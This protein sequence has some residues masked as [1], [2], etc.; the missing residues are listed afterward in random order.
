MIR[1]RELVDTIEFLRDSSFL[2]SAEYDQMTGGM[3]IGTFREAAGR[4][5][6]HNRQI[7]NERQVCVLYFNI[8]DFKSYNER[9]GFEHG[10]GLIMSWGDFIADAFP[11]RMVAHISGDQFAALVYTDEAIDGIKKVNENFRQAVLDL[12]HNAKVGIFRIDSENTDVATACDKAKI[13]ADSIKKQ[14]G[15]YYRYYDEA[16][17]HETI[18]RRYIVANIERAVEEGY[19]K[20]FYQPVIRTLTTKVCGL[21]A[22]C[23]WDD[24]EYG[25]LRPDIIIS[26]LE[27]YH[28]IDIL[29]TYMIRKM[30]EDYAE[31]AK[32]GHKLA[33]ISF[34]VSRLDFELCD[35][36][37]VLRDA[38]EENHVPRNMIHIEIT[39]SVLTKNPEYIRA[40]ITKFHDEGY[41]VWMDDFGSG[42]SS[43]N[44][45]KDFDFDV[46]KID[47][48]F[49]RQF[50]ARSR[51]IIAAIVGMAKQ[52]GIRTLAEGVETQEQLEFLRDIGCE[53]AQGYL[54]GKPQSYQDMIEHLQE[55]GYDF[56]PVSMKDYYDE[57]GTINLMST[58]PLEYDRDVVL[59]PD[60]AVSTQA[61][62]VALYEYVNGKGHYLQVN[63]AYKAE[64]ATAGIHSVEEAEQSML[65]EDSILN[66][67][68]LSYAKEI[69]GTDEIASI[70]FVLNGNYCII[71]ARSVSR[72]GDASAYLVTLQNLSEN[73]GFNQ[74]AKLSSV[75]PMLYLSFEVVAIFYPEENRSDVVYKNSG[76]LE[77]KKVTDAPM[78]EALQYY[79][80]N[81]IHKDDV[82]R[83]HEF[84]DLDTMEQRVQ[85]AGEHI[86]TDYFRFLGLD[87]EYHWKQLTLSSTGED[88]S[89]RVLFSVR[90]TGQSKIEEYTD[91]VLGTISPVIVKE[92]KYLSG[93]NRA[94]AVK[95]FKVTKNPG[96]PES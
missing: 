17:D 28:L 8:E 89:S 84:L 77:D 34:N 41:Q 36:H 14:H 55:V 64:L 70:D 66:D 82:H 35:I 59:A 88:N 92:L 43:L 39:E 46:L 60:A 80:E 20:V 33:P 44:V 3:T 48:E 24:P 42:Y 47:M 52:L 32:A 83:I 5:V 21:E 94:S 71:Q 1:S 4:L 40:Q 2:Q 81:R 74:K 73:F 95:P 79:E 9:Y 13:A 7:G 72:C 86:L 11:D 85:D 16:L 75:L 25:L 6:E 18:R 53:K 69:D 56:E 30:C 78:T 37:Q 26:V 45:L 49:L 58:R 67:R 76:L 10:N 31:A 87:G 62:P 91:P 96:D 22:L 12:P 27:E 15:I 50:S 93:M 19:I 23:R 63:A 65:R 54:I 61:N 90:D 29:D 51:K 68:C 38:V 57:L